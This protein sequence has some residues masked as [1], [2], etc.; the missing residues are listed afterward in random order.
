MK[1]SNIQVEFF[2]NNMKLLG[3]GD[4][5]PTLRQVIPADA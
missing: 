3:R 2:G 4:I 5:K 1:L